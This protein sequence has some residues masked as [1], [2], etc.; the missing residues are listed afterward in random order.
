MLSMVTYAPYSTLAEEAAGTVQQAHHP[1]AALQAPSN[2]RGWE[3]FLRRC[4]PAAVRAVAASWKEVRVSHD[5]AA[6][7][8]PAHSAVSDCAADGAAIFRTAVTLTEGWTVR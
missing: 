7:L 6:A 4:C 8:A 3:S 5:L 2:R 1:A